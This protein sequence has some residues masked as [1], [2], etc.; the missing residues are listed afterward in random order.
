MRT[1]K[2]LTFLI[3]GSLLFPS[4][5]S[6][7]EIK[8]T[9]IEVIRAMLLKSEDR[10]KALEAENK[11]LWTEIAALKN[12]IAPTVI[13]T[14]PVKPITETVTTTN[15]PVK[16]SAPVKTESTGT[17]KYDKLITITND[18]LPRLL[19]DNKI[20]ASATIG[21]YEFVEPN[22][23]FIA[24][25]DGKNEA[26]VT[27]FPYKFLYQYDKNFTI[28]QIGFFKLDQ[29]VQLYTTV[30]GNNP[31]AKAARIRIKNPLYKG[32]LLEFN[33]DGSTKIPTPATTTTTPTTTST[34]VIPTTPI[35]DVT[36]DQIKNAYNKNKLLEALSLSN[37]YIA[38][39]QSN[40]DVYRIRYRSFYILGKLSDSLDAIAKLEA[41]NP[42]DF[43]K[44]I[45]CDGK[46]IAKL[47]KK[48]DLQAHYTGLCKE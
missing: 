33:L 40:A 35:K 32:K 31:H 20:D 12:A 14:T 41:L 5:V 27:A 23:F 9:E 30:S 45:A 18:I 16:T 2:I 37:S 3:V 6:A 8:P 48:T 11:N 44:T 25:D 19:A 4:I 22:A 7:E 47:A 42:S 36:V 34:A 21:M 46:K 43:A 17:E 10:I 28:T 15:T 38:K 26:G 1:Q 24:I 39:D 29:R 13:G